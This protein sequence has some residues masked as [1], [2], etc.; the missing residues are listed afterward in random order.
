MYKRQHHKAIY[1]LYNEMKSA[2]NDKELQVIM[3]KLLGKLNAAGQ[4]NKVFKQRAKTLS[5]SRKR[6][7]KSMM[8]VSVK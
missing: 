1:T 2:D 5:Q 6:S 3:R 4:I 8:S 7:S